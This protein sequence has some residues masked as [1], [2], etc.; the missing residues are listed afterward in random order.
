MHLGRVTRGYMCGECGVQLEE[1]EVGISGRNNVLTGKCRNGHELKAEWPIGSQPP[2]RL[3][4][5]TQF[6]VG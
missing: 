6:D 2:E 5:K 3:P 1:W 4:I